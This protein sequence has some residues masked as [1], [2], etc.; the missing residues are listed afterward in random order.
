MT[1][2]KKF[3]IFSLLA[4]GLAILAWPFIEDQSRIQRN[5][6]Y[7]EAYPEMMGRNFRLPFN[8]DASY[9]V[10]IRPAR[11]EFEFITDDNET[12][13]S[14]LDYHIDGENRLVF[15]ADQS[16]KEHDSFDWMLESQARPDYDTIKLESLDYQRE[17]LYH[18][19]NSPYI[20]FLVTAYNDK[21]KELNH[22]IYSAGW[23]FEAFRTSL[24]KR[25][26]DQDKKEAP[27]SELVLNR[28]YKEDGDDCLLRLEREGEELYLYQISAEASDI[29]VFSKV[30]KYRINKEKFTSGLLDKDDSSKIWGYQEHDILKG[31][32][33]IQ[34]NQTDFFHLSP[35]DFEKKE[36]SWKATIDS[37]TSDLESNFLRPEAEADLLSLADQ[38]LERAKAYS[39]QER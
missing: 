12:S 13:T 33:L 8:G 19:E 10:T 21:G 28:W 7:F 17:N 39:Q 6:Q 25:D 23:D 11:L 32:R 3:Y 34:G 1:A 26:A 15:Q 27:A 16:F 30:N 22:V 4:V 2:N 18:G 38:V 24:F 20:L 31:Q 9:D 5:R 37:N 14:A 36:G 35:Y 29:E